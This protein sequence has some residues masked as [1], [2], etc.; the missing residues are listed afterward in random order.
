MFLIPTEDDQKQLEHK[1]RAMCGTSQGPVEPSVSLAHHV[2]LLV[3]YPDKSLDMNFPQS[4]EEREFQCQ[5]WINWGTEDLFF[6]VALRKKMK[7]RSIFMVL[8]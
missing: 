2:L 4:F 3:E 1:Q 6:I 7:T 8:S 5:T